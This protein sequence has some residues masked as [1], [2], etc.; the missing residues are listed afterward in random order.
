MPTYQVIYSFEQDGWTC[1][2]EQGETV[3]R[4]NDTYIDLDHAATEQDAHDFA[5]RIGAEQNI[6]ITSVTMTDNSIV[7]AD[8]Q[9]DIEIEYERCEHCGKRPPV[10]QCCSAHGKRLCHRCY[11]TTHY[12]EVCT[13]GCEACTR[14]RLPLVL[15]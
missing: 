9:V 14:E 7:M 10:G 4:L 5:R 11:R 8:P 15:R 13:V 12:V 3:D 2:G 1:T 6:R